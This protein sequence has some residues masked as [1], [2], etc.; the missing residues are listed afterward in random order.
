MHDESAFGRTANAPLEQAVAECTEPPNIPAD[1]ATG[2]A[3]LLRRFVRNRDESAFLSLIQRYERLVMGVALRQV[4]DRHQAEDVFQATF[5]VLAE[6][7]SRIRQ[8]DS[9]ASW[10][11]GTARRIGLRVIADQQRLRKMNA[12]TDSTRSVPGPLQEIQRTYEQQTLDTELAN[13]PEALREPLVLHYL[14]GMTGKEVAQRLKLSVDTVEGRLKKGRS[15][16]RQRLVRRGVGF[17]AVLVACQL[18]RQLAADAAVPAVNSLAAQTVSAALNWSTHQ[19][20][21][22]CTANAARLAGKEMAHMAA[23]KTLTLLTTTA[24]TFLVL[25]V[26]A[27]IAF[28]QFGGGGL[29]G[30]PQKPRWIETDLGPATEAARAPEGT[31]VSAIP[32]EQI[33][34]ASKDYRTLTSSQEKVEAILSQPMQ[35][36]AIDTDISTL[37]DMIQQDFGIGVVIDTRALEDEGVASDSF[38]KNVPPGLT[39]AEFLELALDD[40]DNVQLDY[41]IKDGVLKITTRTRAD[42]TLDTRIYEVRQL[43][44][45]YLPQDI[46]LLIESHTSGWVSTGEGNGAL[47]IIPGAVVVSQTQRVH[48]AI[49][50]LLKQLEKLAAREDLPR[51]ERDPRQMLLNSERPE[52]YGGGFGDSGFGG[53]GGFIGGYPDAM[54]EAGMQPAATGMEPGASPTYPGAAA[55]QPAGNLPPANQ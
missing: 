26:G 33:L 1:P 39:V 46:A 22:G 40:V 10:L 2:D 19:T 4:G 29:G 20:L 34:T 28:G 31:A 42:E 24:T 45:T 5:L 30:I 16:L 9:L 36:L 12:E 3:E 50:E 53:G 51:V 37:A 41:V 35:D 48:R 6:Q 14:E 17:G 54:G 52:F 27:A 44:P 11:H 8:P 15:L 55:T 43:A 23:S 21:T 7:A 47:T 13:L 49:A 25:G 38:L 18:F 32:S